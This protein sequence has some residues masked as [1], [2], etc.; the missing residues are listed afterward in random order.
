MDKV[1]VT[2]FLYFKKREQALQKKERHL[3]STK[4]IQK[5]KNSK[6]RAVYELSKEVQGAGGGGGT[7]N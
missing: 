7:Q 3:K 5:D 2:V 1:I 6:P 4:S